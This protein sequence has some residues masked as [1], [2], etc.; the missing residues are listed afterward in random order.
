[1]IHV[2]DSNVQFAGDLLH[3]VAESMVVIQHLYEY[4][5]F[6]D[7]EDADKWLDDIPDA[8]RNGVKTAPTFEDEPEGLYSIDDDIEIYERM[9]GDDDDA[10]D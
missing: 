9:L 6:I 7:K 10:D 5:R 1:M 4:L 3:T 8:I 2:D